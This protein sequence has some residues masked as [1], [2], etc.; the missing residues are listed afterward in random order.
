MDPVSPVTA[1]CV[2]QNTSTDRT[3]ASAQPQGLVR[4]GTSPPLWVHSFLQFHHTRD[5]V[6][7]PSPVKDE[8]CDPEQGP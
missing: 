4:N 6:L 1:L 8:P 2:P 3:L 5:R 7:D